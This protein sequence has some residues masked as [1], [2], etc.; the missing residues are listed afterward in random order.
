MKA[1]VH[2][3]PGQRGMDNVDDPAIIDPTD[4][5]VR[6]DTTTEYA[7]VPLADNSGKRVGAAAMAGDG[8]V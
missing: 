8:A 5:V 3:G 2:H 7:R 6:I 1:L 4:I